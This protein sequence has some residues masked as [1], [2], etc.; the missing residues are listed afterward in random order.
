MEQKYEQ[1]EEQKYEQSEK[2]SEQQSEEQ[3]MRQLLVPLLL[4]FGE[5]YNILRP[6]WC[7]YINNTT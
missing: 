4:I 7:Q 3:S 2:Q 5:V 6:L 1:S